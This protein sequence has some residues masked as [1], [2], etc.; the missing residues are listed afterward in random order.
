MVINTFRRFLRFDFLFVIAVASASLLL[1]P[2]GAQA[3][4]ST[5]VPPQA[6]AV[7]SPKNISPPTDSAAMPLYYRDKE[8][9]LSMR[10]F[11]ASP[12][13]SPLFSP[14]VGLNNAKAVVVH[15]WPKTPSSDCSA[16][17]QT[18]KALSEII[19]TAPMDSPVAVLT[20]TQSEDTGQTASIARCIQAANNKEALKTR[21]VFGSKSSHL[22]TNDLNFRMAFNHGSPDLAA[23]ILFDSKKVAWQGFVG[24]LGL[25]ELN[26]TQEMD[27]DNKQKNAVLYR[28]GEI[29]TAL[30]KILSALKREPNTAAGYNLRI[31]VPADSI[32]NFENTFIASKFHARL[33]EFWSGFPKSATKEKQI[34]KSAATA[35]IKKPTVR[36]LFFTNRMHDKT[37]NEVYKAF[38]GIIETAGLQKER[39]AGKI[40]FEFIPNQGSQSLV[41]VSDQQGYIRR[42]ILTDGPLGSTRGTEI[43]STI[44]NLLLVMTTAS[45]FPPSIAIPNR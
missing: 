23:T 31:A 13:T 2:A 43:G 6:P 27:A 29:K 26:N 9:A 12:K 19:E 22:T 36:V 1:Q 20:I 3:T 38:G 25:S 24:P 33:C 14:P 7:P 37:Q 35:T 18:L 8:A 32:S 30:G 42:A 44:R 16:E 28:V 39:K 21:A 10:F 34:C 45:P 11:P 40:R 15:L 17:E 5:P 4:G 41:V